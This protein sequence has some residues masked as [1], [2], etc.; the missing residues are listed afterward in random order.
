MS[1]RDTTMRRPLREGYVEEFVS[2]DRG[3][4]LP[5]VRRDPREPFSGDWW[6]RNLAPDE[7]FEP[8]ESRNDK[9]RRR[10]AEICKLEKGGATVYVQV[11]AC[12][13]WPCDGATDLDTLPF[14]GRIGKAGSA[15]DT[16]VRVTFTDGAANRVFANNLKILDHI[17]PEFAEEDLLGKAKRQ[18]AGIKALRDKGETVYVR[19][20]DEP[21]RVSDGKPISKSS[22]IWRLA[23]RTGQAVA[24]GENWVRAA[25]TVG[26]GA[27]GR[28]QWTAHNLTILTPEDMVML[29]NGETP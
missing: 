11:D 16:T 20:A 26:S 4:C 18:A 5:I 24:T 14:A 21:V 7:C 6:P 17:P 12:P 9:A 15:I 29:A 10:V 27:V 22:G 8:E 3:N 25:W 28:E 23:G 13:V 1:D 2:T 19:M